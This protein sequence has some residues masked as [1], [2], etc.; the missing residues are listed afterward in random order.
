MQ[1][2]TA[3]SRVLLFGPRS[4]ILVA[5]ICLYCLSGLPL[6]LLSVAL[7]A[8]EPAR[9]A[10]LQIEV[11]ATSGLLE[12]PQDG[13]LFVILGRRAGPEPRLTVGTPGRDAAP[14]LARDVS[15]FGPGAVGVIDS[16][17]AAFPIE[18]LAHL[19]PDDYWVQA[20][21]DRSRDLKS[22]N[23]PGNL[24][25]APRKMHLDPLRDRVVRLEL[26]KRI[27]AESLP[28][29]TERHKYV[30]LR[31]RAAE[32]IPSSPHFPAPVS[33][34]QRTSALSP[35]HTPSGSTSAAT[36]RGTLPEIGI[37]MTGR[38]WS[39]SSSMGPARLEIPIKSTPTTT[40][41]SATPSCGS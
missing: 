7:G 24:Y 39:S 11:S 17:A 14:T 33:C 32:R 1:I 20:V 2:S 34:C 40:G 12:T 8:Q 30:K 22:V 35:D 18:N 23:A 3:S 37:T 25:S 6:R 15:G 13:R 19:P 5:T 26:T 9:T 29:D 31:L 21:F 38:K 36:A 16:R 28:T 4:R 41:P 10:T 27:P